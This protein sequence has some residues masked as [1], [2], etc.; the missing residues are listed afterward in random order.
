MC[1]RRT[2]KL[3][4]RAAGIVARVAETDAATAEEMLRRAD[5]EPKIAIL[6]A[7]GAASVS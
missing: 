2:Q 3:R 4:Q 6:L 7:A 1:G 5:F